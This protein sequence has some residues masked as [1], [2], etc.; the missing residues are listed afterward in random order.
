M[1]KKRV[2]STSRTQQLIGRK[3]RAEK[4][5][6]R[7]R[8]FGLVRVPLG[9]MASAATLA[10]TSLIPAHRA[11]FAEGHAQIGLEQVML[12][13]GFTTVT[14]NTRIFSPNHAIYVDIVEANEVINVSVCGNNN[15][16]DITVEVFETIP[17]IDDPVLVPTTGAEIFA[18]GAIATTTLANSNVD[19]SDPLTG[20]LTNPL[21]FTAPTP[22]TYEVRLTNVNGIRLRR[23]DVTVTSPI[24]STRPDANFVVDP[25]L[26][27]G[28]AYAYSC[29]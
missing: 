1:F 19:C 9:R 8:F 28:R 2:S 27:L 26:D 4:G 21:Q 13:N 11:V 17:N 16:N 5:K 24:G 6:W 15:T 7:E 22:G 18:D 29:A 23:V 12:E 14:A 25:T 20:V 3:G 10:L